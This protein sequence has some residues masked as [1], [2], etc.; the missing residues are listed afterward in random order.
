MNKVSRMRFKNMSKLGSDVNEFIIND[1]DGYP[2]Y[3][4]ADNAINIR[5]EKK[6]DPN[7]SKLLP[8]QILQ[9]LIHDKK[10]MDVFNEMRMEF[11]SGCKDFM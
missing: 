2:S 8:I 7:Y 3:L 4:D 9:I 5:L 1:Q 11:E 10:F 6:G